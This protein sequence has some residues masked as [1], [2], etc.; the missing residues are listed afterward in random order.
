M[1]EGLLATKVLRSY[2][3]LMARLRLMLRGR[4]QGV[5]QRGAVSFGWWSVIGDRAWLSGFAMERDM[6]R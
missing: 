2:P 6:G 4:E 3:R 5:I 1:I